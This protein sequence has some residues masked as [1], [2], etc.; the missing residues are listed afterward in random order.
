M[1]N[2]LVALEQRAKELLDPVHYDFFAGGAGDEVALTD[3]EQAFRRLALLPR[4]LRDTSRRSSA[5]NLLG[6]PSSMPVFVSPTA[7]HKLAHAEGELATARGVASAGLILIA[8]MAATVTIGE[9][10]TAAR[11]VDRDARVWF[12]LY[13][14]PESKVTE[15]L[16]RRAE[17]AGCTALVV[18]V[19]SPALGRRGRDDYHG[20]HDLPAG[21]YAEN[22]RGLPGVTGSGVRR[23]EMSSDFTWDHL[24]RLRAMTQLPVVLKGILHPEDARLAVEHGA[25]AILVSNHG[26]RQLDIAPATLDAMPAIT[27]AVAGR[28][29]VFLDGGVRRGS[30]VVLALALGATAAG[31]GRPVLWGLAVG[32]DKGVTGVLDNLRTEFEN[33]LTLCGVTALSEL[34]PGMVIARGAA[35]R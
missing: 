7:F 34:D 26:G 22:M 8:S 32:G 15:E 35:A 19:D 6:D 29:P 5:T 17:R 9:I 4:V 13:L 23:I 30:D 12:Q 1:T 33:T 2:P 31:V 21:L 27:A 16:V 10:T 11:K 28:I 14:Q 25:D 3:N 20:F 18:T 24:H